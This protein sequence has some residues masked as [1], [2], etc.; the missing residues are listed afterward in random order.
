MLPLR[1]LEKL[2]SKDELTPIDPGSP[3]IPLSRHSLFPVHQRGQ[4]C[5]VLKND[6]VGRLV[7]IYVPFTLLYAFCD[8]YE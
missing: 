3:E 4:G 7:V 6:I 5:P 8:L 2:I 1:K